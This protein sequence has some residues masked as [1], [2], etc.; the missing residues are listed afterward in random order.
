MMRRHGRGGPAAEAKTTEIARLRKMMLGT[1]VQYN[2]RWAKIAYI[3][4]VQFADGV[5][6]GLVYDEKVGKHSGE[7][8]GVRYFRC[9]PSHGAYVPLDK[10]LTRPTDAQQEQDAPSQQPAV[11]GPELLQPEP[12]VAADG[13]A[14]DFDGRD[15]APVD[16]QIEKP[17]S[18]I[19]DRKEDL[20]PSTFFS[21]YH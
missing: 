17:V 19:R 5:F 12:I 11:Q 13:P 8:R 15:V 21:T 1:R 4:L 6:A 14:V 9:A 20:I 2:E 10:V 3:G 18:S 16:E 7:V